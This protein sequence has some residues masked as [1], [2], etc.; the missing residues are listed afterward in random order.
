MLNEVRVSYGRIGFTFGLQP[1]T[2]ANPLATAPTVTIN[3]VQGWGIPTNTPQGRFHNT[4]QLQDAFSITQGTHSMKFGFDVAQVRVREPALPLSS[5]ELSAISYPALIPR[6]ATL[7]M[8]SP[9]QAAHRL[10]RTSAARQPG[11]PLPTRPIM[12][13]ITGR[14]RPVSPSIL[15][16]ATSIMARRSTTSVTLRSTRLI[17]GAS[18]QPRPSPAAFR[19]SR[20]TRTSLPGSVLPILPVRATR[21]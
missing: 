8:T 13:K 19:S 4:Y 18:Q 20:I 2:L 15:V 14:Q 11:R 7:R 21:P 9:A 16:F 10:T 12:R 3:G 17:L 5:T 6:W 1:A